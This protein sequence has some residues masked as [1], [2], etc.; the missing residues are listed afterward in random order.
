MPFVHGT[1]YT[2]ISRGAS[3]GV[4][5]TPASLG[6]ALVW[7][8][9][10]NFGIYTDAGTT[11]ATADGDLIYRWVCRASGMIFDRT[12]DGNRP[13]LKIG[14]NGKRY[15]DWSGAKWLL[16]A[17]HSLPTGNAARS[18]AI[19][20]K[21]GGNPAFVWSY[22]VLGTN[23]LYAMDA[24]STG[25]RVVS[26]NS[27]WDSGVTLSVGT[28]Q[29]V[30]SVFDG[31]NLDLRKDGGTPAT[32]SAF[33]FNTSAGAASLGA[34]DTGGAPYSGQSDHL[35]LTNTA[36]SAGDR[37]SLLAFMQAEAPT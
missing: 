26:I 19:G 30:D 20:L 22:G 27:D 28:R 35:V 15:I 11:P 14:A 37:A 31:T 1:R 17:T 12:A 5:W 16:C 34:V 7:W 24:V 32:T 10:P 25:A 9:D 4:A 8:M 18:F 21:G 29:V 13:T 2:T 6:A 23:L 3:R 36:L 33:T